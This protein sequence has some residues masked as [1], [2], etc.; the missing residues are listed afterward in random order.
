MFNLLDWIYPRHCPICDTI[1]PQSDG[2]ICLQCLEKLDYVKEPSCKKCGK[3]IH[4][5]QK[6]YC[7]DCEKKEHF[8]ESGYSLFT[9]NEKLKASIYRFKYK[10]RVEYADFY[11]EEI[12]KRL[13]KKIS[14]WKPDALVPVPLHKSREYKRGYNQS[15]EIA[16]VIGKQLEIPVR[17][18]LL[19]RVKKTVPQKELD[20]NGR[21]NNLK[22]A[23]K[24]RQNDVKLNT[25]IIIDDI[26]TTGSTVDAVAVELLHA[27]VQKIHY[28]ALAIG[29]Y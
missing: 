19:Y 17:N 20:E 23:F 13:G 8:F 22:K 5:M 10:G 25:I 27:G 4:S 21:Q 1:L 7:V 18:D 11:G 26:Y 16:K 28:I 12:A 6:E 2:K 29:E 3:K 9:Y 24:L 15:Y 14:G